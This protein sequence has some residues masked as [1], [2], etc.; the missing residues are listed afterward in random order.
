LWNAVYASAHVKFN[1]GTKNNV[2]LVLSDGND[3]GSTH[4]FSDALA[5]VQKQ[6]IAVYAIQYA[7]S[8]S[9]RAPSAELERLTGETGGQLFDLRKTDF[10]E[11]ISRIVNDLHARYILTFKPESTEKSGKPHSVEVQVTPPALVVRA[12]RQYSEP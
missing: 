11:V 7:D 5:E 8:W 3:T 10:A 2:L 12:R 1:S 6:G 4:S 9:A